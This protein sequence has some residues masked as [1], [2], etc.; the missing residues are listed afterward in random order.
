VTYRSGDSPTTSGNRAAK[1]VA[2]L[3]VRITGEVVGLDN[4]SRM[5]ALARPA[6]AER[7]LGNVT[8]LQADAYA[9]GPPSSRSNSGHFG[10]PPV[11]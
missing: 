5:I 8:L 6:I 3:R 1:T 10:S 7:G 2:L 4:E 11:P 9:S